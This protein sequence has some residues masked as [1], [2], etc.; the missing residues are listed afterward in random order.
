MSTLRTF[1]VAGSLIAT[2]QIAT[3]KDPFDAVVC[4]GDV[5]KALVG[6]NTGAEPPFALEKRHIA[7]G[8]KAEGGDEIRGEGSVPGWVFYESYTLCGAS[9]HL[10]EKGGVIRDVIRADHSKVSPSFL[11]TCKVD[12]VETKN[13]VLAV[14]YAGDAESL[15]AKSAWRIDESA[16]K[17]VSMDTKGLTCPRSGIATADGGR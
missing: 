1:A 16:A 9:Y 2:A 4:D 5:A 12:G 13:Q 7:I 15:P 10:L 6:Q 14:L 17:F 8:L 11:G 3:A